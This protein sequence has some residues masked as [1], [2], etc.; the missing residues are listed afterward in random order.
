V[1]GNKYIWYNLYRENALTDSAAPKNRSVKG[2]SYLVDPYEKI[3]VYW[4]EVFLNDK[5]S[6][7]EDKHT[8]S[9]VL[10]SF[11]D[12]LCEGG[13]S[14]LDFGCGNGTM[15][16][17]CALRGTKKHIGIDISGEGIRLAKER[18]KLLPAGE[19][20]FI[21]G[22]VVTLGNLA[23][24]SMDGVVLSNILDN[25][26]PEDS[27]EVLKHT[28][29]ILRAGK[30]ALVKLN[31]YLTGKQIEEWNIK[32]IEGD[33]LDDGLLLWN[34]T[35]EKWK[36]LLEQFFVIEEQ[37]DVYYREHDQ[38]NRLFLL[39]KPAVGNKALIG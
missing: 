7:P 12:R 4:D 36:M 15:L 21:E 34:Q 23:S 14:L 28:H 25:V 35:D 38:H 18:A 26:T 39:R 8:F 2:R 9:D 22:G 13:A 30:R 24:D 29:R 11:L 33:L 16:F 1:G 6:V 37:S 19:F 32:I 10:D 27:I 17:Y 31:P 20:D 5:V 3:R